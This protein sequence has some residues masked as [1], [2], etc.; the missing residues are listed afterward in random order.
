MPRW[1]T[2]TA[3]LGILLTSATMAWAQAER[4]SPQV[5]VLSAPSGGRAAPTIVRGAPAERQAAPAAGA[6]DGGR[7][8]IV[9]GER[10]WLV[11]RASGEIRGCIDSDTST[12]GVREILCTSGEV[13]RFSRTFGRNFHP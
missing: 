11:D 6:Q 2:L 10:L 9:A 8:Q 12:V 4:P 5:L 1:T 7:W 3:A 13:G